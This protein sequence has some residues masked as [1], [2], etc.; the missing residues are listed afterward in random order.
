MN[1]LTEQQIIKELQEL[2]PFSR[3]ELLDFLAFLRGRQQPPLKPATSATNAFEIY[4]R[5]N[6]GAGGNAYCSSAQAK[7]GIRELLQHK[8]KSS[9]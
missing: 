4:V 8:R 7:Q 9:S 2:D 6:L 5:L 3:Q 1:T